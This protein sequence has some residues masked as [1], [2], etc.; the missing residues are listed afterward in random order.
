MQTIARFITRARKDGSVDLILGNALKSNT[1]LK[2]DRVY[3]LREIM[4]E[5]L[6]FD[7]GECIVQDPSNQNGEPP[8]RL[9]WALNIGDLVDEGGKTLWLTKRE[10]EFLS[11]KIV[12][13]T[14][15]G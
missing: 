13:D 14:S 6:V 10:K 5:I 2:P 8:A 11:M 12:G 15:H 3:E 1:V 9:S 7:I 4:G